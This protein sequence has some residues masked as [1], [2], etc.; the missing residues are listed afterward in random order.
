MV[1]SVIEMWND[2]MEIPQ[3]ASSWVGV[4]ISVRVIYGL[5][6]YRNE[7]FDFLPE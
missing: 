2:A 7:A 3:M 1:R 4:V 5:S 6:A